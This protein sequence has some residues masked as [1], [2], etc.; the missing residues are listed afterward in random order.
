MPTVSRLDP[1]THPALLMSFG[2][3]CNDVSVPAHITQQ[4]YRMLIAAD[5]RTSAYSEHRV[6]FFLFKPVHF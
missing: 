1:M 5:R 2:A 3:L 4:T 6:I